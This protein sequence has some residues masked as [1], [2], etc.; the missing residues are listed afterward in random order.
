MLHELETI[1]HAPP[2]RP[3][4]K[5]F[6]TREQVRDLLLKYGREEKNQRTLEAERKTMIE[7]GL[8]PKDFPFEDFAVKLLTEQIAGF[9]DYRTHELNLLD[10][11]PENLQIPVLAHELTHA[12]QDQQ[13]NLKTFSDA[14]PH[15]DDLSEARESLVEGDATAMMTDYLL[16]QFGR[17][18]K[19][20]GIDVRQIIEKGDQVPAAG[21]K[22]YQE[23]PRAIKTELAAPYVYG[24]S[25]IQFFLRDNDWPQIN[26]LYM[27]PPKSM[28][29]IMHPEKYFDHRDDP[30]PVTLPPMPS[31]FLKQW[32]IVDTNVLGELGV[33]IVLQQFLNQDNTKIASEGW[34][35][36]QYQIYQDA[37]GHLLL[38]WF[39]NWDTEEDAEQF[40]NAYQV[41][42]EK[43]Y[44]HLKVLKADDKKFFHYDS[45]DGEIGVEMKG[46]DVVVMEGVPASDFETLRALLWQSKEEAPQTIKAKV[47]VPQS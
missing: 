6:R 40:F 42:L 3:F 18:L 38:M 21:M 16:R 8:I 11:T 47:T 15:N 14:A 4:R 26:S 45:S 31:A 46:E 33:K 37:A 20:L 13:F 7:F 25:F 43:K 39:S 19:T 28:E 35:G 22:V 29:Q 10:S 2:P 17:N 23:A 30:V 36:D 34:G 1:R 44:S 9:Y 24:T 27:D 41:L 32:K 5:V 12:L